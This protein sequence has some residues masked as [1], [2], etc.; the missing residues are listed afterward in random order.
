[1]TTSTDAA[2]AFPRTP[3]ADLLFGLGSVVL[4]LMALPGLLSALYFSGLA[5]FAYGSRLGTVI[6]FPVLA[7]LVCSPFIA[8]AAGARRA[9]TAGRVGAWLVGCTA[10]AALPLWLTIA[11]L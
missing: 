1:M 5:G 6:A 2:T 10:A 7:A 4:V 8:F 9:T 11:L 3:A